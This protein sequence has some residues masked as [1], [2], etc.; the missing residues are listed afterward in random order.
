MGILLLRIY[1][2]PYSIYSRGT[3]NPGFSLAEPVGVQMQKEDLGDAMEKDGVRSQTYG[4]AL[5]LWVSYG[6]NSFG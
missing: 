3:L 6:R 2:R 5:G 1:P 4:A